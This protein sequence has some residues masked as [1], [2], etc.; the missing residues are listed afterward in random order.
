M[1]PFQRL[2]KNRRDVTRFL[3]SR[4]ENFDVGEASFSFYIRDL[5]IRID[6]REAK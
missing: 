6:H 4:C 5:A 1:E 3:L 2:D